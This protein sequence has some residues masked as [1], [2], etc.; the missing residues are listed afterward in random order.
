MEGKLFRG[1]ENV[2]RVREYEGGAATLAEESLLDELHAIHLVQKFD[3]NGKAASD[4]VR[5][6]PVEGK[7]EPK[8]GFRNRVAAEILLGAC[9]GSEAHL[10]SMLRLLLEMEEVWLQTRQRSEAEQRVVEELSKLRDAYGRLRLADLQAAYQ[11]AKSNFPSLR[12]P[13]KVQL[14]WTKWSPLVAPNKVLYT[15]A[16]LKTFWGG[17]RERWAERKWFR[18]P[19]LR[20]PLYLFRDAQLS[21]MFFLYLMRPSSRRVLQTD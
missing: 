10:G 3:S 16:D 2:L 4:D 21:A 20:M 12:V 8:A 19:V 7:N 1:V 9:E 15:R 17:V 11:K 14:F 6:F 18:L 13:S 5:I